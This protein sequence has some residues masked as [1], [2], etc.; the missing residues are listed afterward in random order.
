MSKIATDVNS[1][2]WPPSFWKSL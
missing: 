1:R 2:W